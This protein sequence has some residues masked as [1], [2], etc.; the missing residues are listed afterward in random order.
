MTKNEY[1][2]KIEN[3]HAELHNKLNK[4]KR[5][6]DEGEIRNLNDT[7]QYLLFVQKHAMETYLE[8]LKY[9]IDDIKTH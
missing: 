4:L 6:I 8:C 3:E 9:R 5:F 1:L 7:Q 2:V